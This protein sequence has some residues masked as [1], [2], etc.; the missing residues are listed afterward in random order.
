MLRSVRKLRHMRVHASDG[1]VGRVDEVY[2][3]DMSWGL[4]HIVVEIDRSLGG[5]R[6]LV[7]P[8]HVSGVDHCASTV[9]LSIPAGTA[10]DGP[11]ADSDMP[12]CR[13]KEAAACRSLILP[14]YWAG[15][16]VPGACGLS[17]LYLGTDGAS[18]R[19]SGTGAHDAHLRS[20]REVLGYHL[21]VGETWIGR[22]DDFL[23]EESEW[24][25]LFIQAARN[26]WS[27][28][29]RGRFSTSRVES[30]E[31]GHREMVMDL[32]AEAMRTDREWSWDGHTSD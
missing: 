30:I 10:A 27:S 9:H 23:F 14:A 29:K 18:D 17:P 28:V 16:G 13:Q 32:P 2:F 26:R 20:S 22:V 4:R 24:R 15:S 11:G 5:R 3:D 7:P 19:E 6:V 31:W 12:V 1:E 25:I 21:R 8:A